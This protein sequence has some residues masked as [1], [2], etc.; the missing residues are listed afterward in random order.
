MLL[1]SYWLNIPEVLWKSNVVDIQA[2]IMVGG[3]SFY[4]LNR[5]NLIH[6]SVPFAISHLLEYV[7]Q[8]EYQ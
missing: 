8:I 1:R 2:V 7:N 4:L 5:L 6:V 3:Q